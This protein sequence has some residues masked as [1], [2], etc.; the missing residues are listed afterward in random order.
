[1]M[2]D[3]HYI[4]IGANRVGFQGLQNI[5]LEKEKRRISGF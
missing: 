1:M 4:D 2:I 5:V 3:R